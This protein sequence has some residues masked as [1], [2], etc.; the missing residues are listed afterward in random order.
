MDQSKIM[1]LKKKAEEDKGFFGKLSDKTDAYLQEKVVDPL[2]AK[3]YPNLGAGIAA[4]P[5]SVVGVF[6]NREKENAKPDAVMA[7]E[8]VTPSYKGVGAMGSSTGKDVMPDQIRVRLTDEMMSQGK[9]LAE[10]AQKIKELETGGLWRRVLNQER[11][12]AAS[13]ALDKAK[14]MKID[15]LMGTPK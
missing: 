5:S 1:A 4:V 14:Q 7:G 13:K 3:G 8:G 11:S 9:S 10:A 15:D 2:A 12:N 6:A